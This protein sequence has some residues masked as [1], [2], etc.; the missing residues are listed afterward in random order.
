MAENSHLGYTVPMEHPPHP[1]T[2]LVPPVHLL[3]TMVVMYFLGHLLPILRLH[4]HTNILVG[5]GLVLLGFG[6][7]VYCIQLFKRAKAPLRPFTSAKTLVIEG[8]YRFSRNPIYVAMIS[9]VI[10]WAMSLSALSP[11]IG[12]VWFTYIIRKHWVIPEEVQLEAELGQEYI[13]YKKKVRRWL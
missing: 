8:P 7:I 2:T 12:V 11:W 5:K 1:I 9:I 13:K 4:D 3:L 6:M 10:G